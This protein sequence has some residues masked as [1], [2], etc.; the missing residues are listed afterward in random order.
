L[1]SSQYFDSVFG[2]MSLLTQWTRLQASA[3]DAALSGKAI[4]NSDLIRNINA[5]RRTIDKL[6][7]LPLTSPRD[8]SQ[9]LSS[10]QLKSTLDVAESDIKKG[11]IGIVDA[12][13]A[14]KAMDGPLMGMASQVHAHVT[15]E[16]YD[17]RVV[18]TKK[19]QRILI[20]IEVVVVVMIA[21]LTALLLL[22]KKLHLVEEEMRAARDRADQAVT[23]KSKMLT[24]T[25]H[26]LRQPLQEMIIFAESLR[27]E[28]DI[29]A[30]MDLHERL[31][32]GMAT[33]MSLLDSIVSVAELDSGLLQPMY[34]MVS[35]DAIMAP[36]Q[37]AYEPRAKAKGINLIVDYPHYVV[38]RTDPI[39]LGRMLRNLVAN[40]LGH[41]KRGSVRIRSRVKANTLRI[42]IE[43][44]GYGIA[45]SQISSIW[46]EFHQGEEDLTSSNLGMGLSIVRMLADLMKLNVG[47]K[48]DFGK[49]SCFH[50][51]LPV[52]ISLPTPPSAE[53]DVVAVLDEPLLLPTPHAL[54]V[55]VI[56]DN[57]M[58]LEAMKASIAL[59][60]HTAVVASSGQ[61]AAN[62]L[63]LIPFLADIIIS[64]FKLQNGETGIQAVGLVRAR[65]G[66]NVPAIL[67]TDSINE[68]ASDEAMMS[69]TM[70][71]EKPIPMN[72]LIKVI[73]SLAQASSK[74]PVRAA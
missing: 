11:E 20:G 64:D 74:P 61:E 13:R 57:G 38:I 40:A 2:W 48:S 16:V 65:C 31:D 9:S 4:D 68:G 8:M 30:R 5:L 24:A 67:L 3:G 60:G 47:V 71:L 50:I 46:D 58:V 7:E 37:I 19:A 62:A 45:A 70:V 54:V 33:L 59:A 35:L 32:D 22:T 17:N 73:Q 66:Q 72:E 10:G 41:T 29:V 39:L 23:A 63:L 26:D 42:E 43:D 52:E 55:V 28:T 21:L 56:N 34:E 12:I 51:D 27:H 36:I 14:L 49:G 15:Q 18:T 6:D 25:S 1:G 69:Q 44:T 53:L